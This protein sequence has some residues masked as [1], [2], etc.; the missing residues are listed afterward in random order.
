[1][2][3]CKTLIH[4]LLLTHPASDFFPYVLQQSAKPTPGHNLHHYKIITSMAVSTQIKGMFTPTCISPYVY[5]LYVHVLHTLYVRAFHVETHKPFLYAYS[6]F[7]RIWLQPC[8]CVQNQGEWN[9]SAVCQLACF[10]EYKNKNK[11]KH[12]EIVAKSQTR[13]GEIP[14]DERLFKLILLIWARRRWR[15]YLTTAEIF[16]QG[17]EPCWK[18]AL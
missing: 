15:G 13:I 8:T 17:E 4:L 14:E 9:C 16:V 10:Q 2:Q 5:M 1:M 6:R 12:R 3:D 11:T 18:R 7:N